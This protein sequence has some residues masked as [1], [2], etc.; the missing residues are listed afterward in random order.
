GDHAADSDNEIV[1]SFG[2]RPEIPD[3]NGGVVEIGVEDGCQHAALRCASWIA[4]GKIHFQ[5]MYR[6]F[7]D[8]AVRSD[9][10][11]LDV[12]DKTVDFRR[13]AGSAS[14]L[15]QRP[16]SEAF[17]QKVVIEFQTAD[18]R[19]EHGRRVTLVTI[20]ESLVRTFA[21]TQKLPGTQRQN[22]NSR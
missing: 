2:S 13:H 5:M 7:L 20:R 12:V 11:S 19:R 14:D 18:A 22:A 9:E 16:A 6:T 10:Q 21:R 3:T 17:L 4:E 8:L 1:Q 15:D